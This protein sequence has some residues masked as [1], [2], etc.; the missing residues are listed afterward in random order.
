MF[1]ERNPAVLP[2]PAGRAAIFYVSQA[3]Y[4]K[5]LQCI[6]LLKRKLQSSSFAIPACFSL[7]G[8]GKMYTRESFIK[9]SALLL[10]SLHKVFLYDCQQCSSFKSA[11]GKLMNYGKT[12][13]LMQLYQQNKCSFSPTGQLR[14]ILASVDTLKLFTKS[15]P[16]QILF[17]LLW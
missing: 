17:F 9:H 4:T 5:I 7:P 3:F 14:G 8:R 2:Q 12:T 11:L 15:F 13:K 16:F 10:A 6:P 1:Q